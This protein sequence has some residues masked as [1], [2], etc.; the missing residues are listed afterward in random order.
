M[1][2]PDMVSW[3]IKK[4]GLVEETFR[5]LGDWTPERLYH[6]CWV[7]VCSD[8]LKLL[9]FFINLYNLIHTKKYG[10]IYYC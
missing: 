9:L 5:K 6:Q 8:F 10:D 3:R 2:I 4:N 1:S 7:L